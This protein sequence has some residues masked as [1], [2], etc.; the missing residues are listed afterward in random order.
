M[1]DKEIIEEAYKD[2]FKNIYREFYI[3]ENKAQFK[4]RLDKLKRSKTTALSL[5]N[6]Q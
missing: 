3:D 6:D 1:N 2:I 5:L 4:D